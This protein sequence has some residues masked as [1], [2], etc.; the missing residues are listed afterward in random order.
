MSWK[1]R[2]DW[3]YSLNTSITCFG[4]SLYISQSITWIPFHFTQYYWTYI[5]QGD[6]KV[7]V[8]LIIT[9]QKVYIRTYVRT[10]VRTYI[11]TYI[12]THRY[13]AQSACLAAD[14]QDQGDTRVT[15]TP[16]VIPNSKSV[17]TVSDWNCLKYFAC[18]LYCNHQVHRDFLISRY[19][20]KDVPADAG[21][22][23]VWGVGLRPFVSW[24]CGFESR[25][26]HECLSVVN[27]VY[28]GRGLWDGPT[29]RPG[30]SYRVVCVCYWVWSSATLT[31]YTLLWVG[32]KN[33]TNKK[34]HGLLNDCL[35]FV[36]SSLSFVLTYQN[37]RFPPYQ[38]P[39]TCD[40]FYRSNIW[41][42]FILDIGLAFV[43]VFAKLL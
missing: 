41:R 39:V 35:E 42:T 5:L 15:P 2:S 16:S 21:G 14:R 11:H 40:V 19:N 32:T 18:F 28:V 9:I 7:S 43:G 33:R 12:N 20:Q 38:A 27:I 29:P 30:E 6:Q 37:D 1:R 26:V 25:R 31:L 4:E 13:L 24:D 34:Y 3:S 17:I 36:L 22:C 8:H 23:A 10:Y